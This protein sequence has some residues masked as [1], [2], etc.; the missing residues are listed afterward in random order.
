[1]ECFS[2]LDLPVQ[3][4]IFDNSF[5]HQALQYLS[6]GQFPSTVDQQMFLINVRWL[7]FADFAVWQKT[8]TL[9]AREHFLQLL[10]PIYRLP[11]LWTLIAD[12]MFWFVKMP[13]FIPAKI[14][15]STINVNLRHKKI[16]S[17]PRRW[18]S[19]KQYQVL[20]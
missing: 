8:G 11:K 18:T 7:M 6:C 20:L 3:W 4:Q 19:I 14:S 15:W 1:M 2:N 17:G 5:L 9:I 12:E 10:Y 16:P 13:T